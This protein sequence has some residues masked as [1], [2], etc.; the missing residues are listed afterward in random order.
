MPVRPGAF[1]PGGQN[2]RPLSSP[3]RP[4]QPAPQTSLPIVPGKHQGL[5]SLI[6]PPGGS[7]LV[8]WW[9]ALSP[10]SIDARA[11]CVHTTH[12]RRCAQHRLPCSRRQPEAVHR[13]WRSCPARRS[14]L[15][16]ANSGRSRRRVPANDVLY[17][18]SEKKMM[19]RLVLPYHAA[20]ALFR[21]KKLFDEPFYQRSARHIKKLFSEKKGKKRW[22]ILPFNGKLPARYYRLLICI[23]R[24]L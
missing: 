7:V 3:Q 19:K 15:H 23:V 17:V 22:A 1:P 21:R 2:R 10:Y 5:R 13:T 16:K 8:A 18:S 4:V 14:A 20:F 12:P 11:R 6:H 24:R 9:A